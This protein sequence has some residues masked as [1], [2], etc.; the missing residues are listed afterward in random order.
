MPD[1]CPRCRVALENPGALVCANCAYAL[2]LPAV[3]KAGAA[4][5]GIGLL[6]FLVALFAPEG[7]WLTILLGGIIL[8]VAGLGALFTSGLLIGRARHA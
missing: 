4:L 6:A 5:L 7:I 2:R 8:L 1:R 3:G